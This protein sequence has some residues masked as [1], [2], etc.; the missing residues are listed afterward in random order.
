[1]SRLAVID[2]LTKIL[3][4]RGITVALLEAM[5]SAERYQHPLSVALVD[6][7]RFKDVNDRFGHEA[8]DQVLASLT[9]IIAAGVRESDRVGRYGGEEFLMVFPETPLESSQP[10]LDRIRAQV[11]EHR[12]DIG[13]SA[14]GVTLSIGVTEF[15]VGED[16]THLFNRVDKA[17]YEAKE[18]GRDLVVRARAATL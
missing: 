18:K 5:A 8:G 4:R 13:S 6:V 16:H 14:I 2:P 12:F 1:M 10:I 11:S 7:D 17:L 3:N 15:E 9:A